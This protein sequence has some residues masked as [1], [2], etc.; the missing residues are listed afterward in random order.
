MHEFQNRRSLLTIMP[1]MNHMIFIPLRFY[2][3]CVLC[4]RKSLSLELH[5]SIGLELET[6][7]GFQHDSVFR[8]EK[9]IPRFPDLVSRNPALWKWPF[10]FFIALSH[11]RKSSLDH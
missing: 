10:G 7:H 11:F 8:Y 5:I 2:L 6:R 3:I 9:Q 4:T 1:L